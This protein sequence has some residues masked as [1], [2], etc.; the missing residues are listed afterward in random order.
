MDIITAI[1]SDLSRDK[2]ETLRNIKELISAGANVNYQDAYKKTPLMYA[3]HHSRIDIV[4]EL[5]QAGADVNIEDFWGSTALKHASTGSL[6]VVKELL[7]A[8]ANVN[9]HNG[10]KY[11]AIFWACNNYRL[12]ILKELVNA[13]ADMNQ[14][15]QYYDTKVTILGY[16]IN[17]RRPDMVDFLVRHICKNI[18][19]NDLLGIVI[20]FI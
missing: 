4:K 16:A 1:N 8:G 14:Y 10:N 7:R 6:D 17:L 11:T 19:S 15:Y 18:I 12:G 13:G 3:C 5:I 2:K 20:T 9:A